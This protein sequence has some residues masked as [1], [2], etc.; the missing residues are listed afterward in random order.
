MKGHAKKRDYMKIGLATILFSIFLIGCV[1]LDYQEVG[2]HYLLWLSFKQD[3]LSI[4]WPKNPSHV[5]PRISLPFSIPLDT[6][7]PL[8]PLIISII[9]VVKIGHYLDLNPFHFCGRRIHHY[10]VGLLIILVGLILTSFQTGTSTILLNGKETNPTE[11]SQGLGL[12]SLISG[13]VFII[14]DSNDLMNRKSK[15]I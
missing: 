3:S 2:S 6:M 12:C 7:V 5:L 15:H 13:I 11:I 10:H 14:L 9:Y 8:I 1:I 4:Y